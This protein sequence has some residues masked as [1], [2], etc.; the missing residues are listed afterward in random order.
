MR[1]EIEILH[2]GQ[3]MRAIK[4]EEVDLSEHPDFHDAYRRIGRFPDDVYTR[5]RNHAALGYL[6]PAEFESNWLLH[7]P[8]LMLK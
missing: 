4:E 7:Q 6:T 1:G 8:E 2:L 5:N 3:V